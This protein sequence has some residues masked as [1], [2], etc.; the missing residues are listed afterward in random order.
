MRELFKRLFSRPGIAAELIAASF[1]ANAL[2]LAT[3]LFVIQVLNRYIA[4][5]VDAT[6]ATLTTGVVLAVIL[7]FAFRQVRTRLARVVSADPD[8]RTAKGSTVSSTSRL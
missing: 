6:L 2:A 8:E 7:E 1:F 3:P 4:H 5:G